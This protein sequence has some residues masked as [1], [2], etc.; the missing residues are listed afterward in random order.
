MFSLNYGKRSINCYEPILFI[1]MHLIAY[2]LFVLFASTI[3]EFSMLFFNKIAVCKY[4][5]NMNATHF[6][7]ILSF[8]I[9]VAGNLYL[10]KANFI[11]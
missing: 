4:G 5:K 11:K 3:F 2:T 7:R 10:H 1:Q 8:H 9:T 6:K